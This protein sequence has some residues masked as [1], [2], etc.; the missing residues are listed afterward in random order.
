MNKKLVKELEKTLGR[1]GVLSR[2]EE[3]LLYEYD[4]GPGQERPVPDAVVFP[5]SNAQRNASQAT[6]DVR[7][8]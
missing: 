6:R 2:P 1:E 8:R 3:L 4:A 7:N 5:Q